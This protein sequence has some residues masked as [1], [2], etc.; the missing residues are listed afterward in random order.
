MDRPTHQIATKLRAQ[1]GVTPTVRLD[2]GFKRSTKYGSVPAPI[3]VVVGWSGE[4]PDSA[5]PLKRELDDA[6]PF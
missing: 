2:V 4:R 3:F 1:P 5:V 6:I